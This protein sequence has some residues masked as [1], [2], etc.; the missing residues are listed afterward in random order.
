MWSPKVSL[1]T[2][3]TLP[4]IIYVLSFINQFSKKEQSLAS[5]ASKG[6]VLKCNMIF[7]DSI[8][9]YTFSKHQNKAEFKHLNDSEVLSSDFADLSP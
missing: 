7:H 1:P 5:T 2:L 9:I 8:K 6:K 4:E 3:M